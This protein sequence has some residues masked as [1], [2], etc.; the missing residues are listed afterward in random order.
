MAICQRP[1]GQSRGATA[2]NAGPI[3]DPVAGWLAVIVSI[4]ISVDA[5]R[6]AGP[7]PLARIRIRVVREAIRPAANLAAKPLADA[8]AVSECV[9]PIHANLWMGVAVAL[10]HRCVPHTQAVG[11]KRGVPTARRR[12]LPADCRICRRGQ[13]HCILTPRHFRHIDA[14]I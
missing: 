9:A 4:G 11:H 5:C 12:V 8:L 7:E 3:V 6:A 2:T 1:H 13:P 14:V 10:A